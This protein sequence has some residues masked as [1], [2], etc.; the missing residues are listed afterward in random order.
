MSTT[1]KIDV[2]M[3]LGTAGERRAYNVLAHMEP[4]RRRDEEFAFVGPAEVDVIIEAVKRGVLELQGDA[5]GMLRLTCSRC[6]EEFLQPVGASLDATF[7]VPMRVAQYEECRRVDGH[8]IDLGPVIEEALMLAL[9]M[10]ILHDDACRGLCSVCGTNLN[11]FPEHTHEASPNT[12]FSELGRLL[13]G[14]FGEREGPGPAD[15]KG[16]G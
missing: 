1:V 13:G 5:S 3:L 16:Q 11:E 15:K 6:L 12:R 4:L 7:C 10:K 14:E 2:S 8:E 9:P